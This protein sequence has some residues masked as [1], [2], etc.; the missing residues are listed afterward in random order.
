MKSFKSSKEGAHVGQ[1]TGLTLANCFQLCGWLVFSL[2]EMSD[3][4]LV[5]LFCCNVFVITFLLLENTLAISVSAGSWN[6]LISQGMG[7]V[8][9]LSLG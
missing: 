4:V 9:G 7:L 8:I 5:V 6:V 1:R 2:C 3:V